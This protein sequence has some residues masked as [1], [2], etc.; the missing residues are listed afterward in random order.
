MTRLSS[1]SVP[2][3]EDAAGALEYFS[4]RG[5]CDSCRFWL[6]RQMFN[7]QLGFCRA[8]DNSEWPATGFCHL[9]DPQPTATKEKQS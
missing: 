3:I 4:Q 9:H 5:T 1:L 8:H 6:R 2:D 7:R